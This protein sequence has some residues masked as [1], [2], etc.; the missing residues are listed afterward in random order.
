MASYRAPAEWEEWSEWLAAGLHGRSRWRLAA[1]V[2]GALFAGGRRVVAA[3][4]RAGGIGDDYRQHYFFLQSVGRRWQELGRRVL[5]LVLKVALAGS[6]RVLL[7]LDDSPSKRY[8]PHVEGAGVHHDPTP[9]PTGSAFCW[10]HVWV[11]L[12]VAVRHRL[13]GTIGLPIWAWLYV[14]EKDVPKLSRH[15]WTFRTKLELGADLVRLAVETLG[16]AGK[17]LWAVVDGAYAMRPFV[18]P[19]MALGVTLVGRLRKDAALRDVPPVRKTRG[20]G[21]P[22]KYGANRI[23]LAKRAAHPQGWQDVTCTVYGREE[24][25]R[26]KTFRATHRTFGGA[27]RVVIVQERTGPQFFYCTDLAASPREIVETFAD[28]AAIEQVFHD[29][30]EVWGSGQQQVRNLWANIAVWNINLWLHTLVELWAWNKPGTDLV[31]RTDSPWDDP[32]RRPSHA[33]RRKSLQAAC[34]EREFSPPA[35][36]PPLPPEIRDLLQRLLRIAA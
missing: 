27:I 18:R 16:T 31:H 25:K 1:I 10:G 20:R 30:K 7:V 28:R 32:D 4:L 17:R 6:D 5:L 22:R 8:G 34:L 11:T 14:R 36:Q 13:W 21:R 23:S 35:G 24:T 9:G 3:W 29:V 12:A 2:G 15:G 26:L 33:D 19:V